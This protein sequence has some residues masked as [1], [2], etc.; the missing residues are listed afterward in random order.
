MPA[1]SSARQPLHARHARCQA[2]DANAE[3]FAAP[4]RA[5]LRAGAALAAGSLL[6]GAVPQLAA[7]KVVSSDWELVR[8]PCAPHRLHQG[9]CWQHRGCLQSGCELHNNTRPRASSLSVPA[10]GWTA[11]T[12]VHR[13]RCAAPDAKQIVVQ[14]WGQDELRCTRSRR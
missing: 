7:A 12:A 10:W 5:L 3:E 1:R 4:R 2:Q 14:C 9:G 6:Q 8:A 11:L 13:V